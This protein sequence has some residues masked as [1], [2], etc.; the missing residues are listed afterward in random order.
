MKKRNRALVTGSTGFIGRHMIEGLL[1]RDYEVFCLIRED[2]NP[3][4]IEG[5]KITPVKAD[6]YDSDSLENAVSGMDYLFHIGAVIDGGNEEVLYK[7]NVEATVNLIKACLKVNPGIKK[8]IFV[9]SIA[10]SGPRS[11]KT[12][13]KESDESHPVSLYGKSK[14]LAELEVM[15]FFTELPI[16]II[17]ATHILGI[18]QKQME[19]T[20]K[21]V[22]KRIVP[23]LGN[24]D[25]QTTICFVEDLVRSMIMS[26]ENRNIRN[27]IYFVADKNPVSWRDMTDSIIKELGISFVI[28]IPYPILISIG[29]ILETVARIS[30]KLPLITRKRIKGV[31][32][33]YW[34]QDVSK[35]EEEIGFKTGIDFAQGMK[36]IVSWYKENKID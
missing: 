1:E 21:L 6:Y 14:H 10:A 35:I 22:K 4:K 19:D 12:P 27:R 32:N 36:N 31:R 34:I 18:Y 29:F 23:V 5:K 33:N 11:E 30:G 2:T 17:R 8:I 24:G 13:V 25:K 15:K 7:A 20:V 16:V 3:K 26:A 9:S 28:K